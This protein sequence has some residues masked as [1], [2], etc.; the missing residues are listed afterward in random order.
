MI[1][2]RR[3]ASRPP[4]TRPSPD[5]LTQLRKPTGLGAF[6]TR[7]LRTPVEANYFLGMVGFVG[8]PGV[9]GVVGVFGVFGV[10][11]AVRSFGVVAGALRRV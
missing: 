6:G 8:V 3:C 4:R 7:C 10:M 9:F 2:S 5:Q 1:S 11:G